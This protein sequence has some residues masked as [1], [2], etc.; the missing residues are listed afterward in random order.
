MFA[1]KSHDVRE[2]RLEALLAE[3]VESARLRENS[4]FDEM[5]APFEQS[6]ILF[7][8]G[9]FGRRTLAG[10][11][12]VGLE[13]LAFADNNPSLWGKAVDGLPVLSPQGAAERFGRRAAFVITIWNGH[14]QDRTSQRVRQLTGLGCRKVIPFGFLYWKYPGTFLPFYPLDL[15]HKVLAQ[16][17]AVMAAFR[18]W[19]DDF[20]RREYLAQVAFRLHLDLDSM[21]S[22][23]V[24]EH[25]FPPDVYRL[26]SRE[27]L[28]DCGA[29]D[30]DTIRSFVGRQGGQF[31][32]IIAYEPDPLSWAKLQQTVAALPEP[33]RRKISCFQ[34]AVGASRGTVAF[35]VTGTEFS[36]AGAGQLMV[37]SVALDECLQG[38][39]PTI[40]KFDIEG[41]E[42]EALAGGR[43]TIQRHTPV[44]AI[45]SYHLQDHLWQLPLSVAGMSGDY[46]YFLRP[47]S[48]EGWDLVCYAVPTGRWIED[49]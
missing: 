36:T 43:R 30:G 29:F 42:P 38:E 13:P 25:Y 35:G 7:G 3:T 8:A 41:A 15:P 40:V 16:A 22:P 34:R 23:E 21:S 49:K 39:T 24:A 26:T 46:R 11:R 31:A 32:R 47:H 12:Q 19:E 37:E 45:S 27:V 2:V 9:Q 6:L 10:L 18:L 14:L 33:V 44:L 1:L 20:S 28:I 4:A 5:A 17:D 48:F